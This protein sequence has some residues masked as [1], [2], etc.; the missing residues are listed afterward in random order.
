AGIHVVAVRGAGSDFDCGAF[1]K[2]VSAQ[3]GG[4]GGGRAENAEGRLPARA[5]DPATWRA[6]TVPELDLRRWPG[7]TRLLR[8]LVGTP[9]QLPG[10][11]GELAA[12]PAKRQRHR[13]HAGVVRAGRQVVV[14]A[15]ARREQVDQH[16]VGLVV[17]LLEALVDLLVAAHHR[18]RAEP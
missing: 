5:V 2:R 18:A 6:L 7:D 13:P 15:P 12:R 3:H 17:D 11:A 1:V 10:G 4:R 8:A 14:L 16:A 9:G